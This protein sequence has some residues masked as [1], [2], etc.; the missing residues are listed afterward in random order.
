MS[1]TVQYPANDPA[2]E[3][4]RALRTRNPAAE[5]EMSRQER[6]TFMVYV[7]MGGMI[8]AFLTATTAV[9]SLGV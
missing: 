1:T 7:V 3:R 2:N 9:W 5:P 6:V 8:L 4:T